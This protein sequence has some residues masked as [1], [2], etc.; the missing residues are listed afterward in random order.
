MANTPRIG[1]VLVHGVGTAGQSD[2]LVDFGESIIGWVAR[3]QRAHGH[4][5]RYGPTRLNF[6]QVD[7]G[8]DGPIPYT[9]LH[10]P[11]EPDGETTQTWVVA[12]AWWA[13]SARP[14]PFLSMLFWSFRYLLSIVCY[15]WREMGERLKR[16]LPQFVTRHDGRWWYRLADA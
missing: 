5:P 12:E 9:T 6:A 14:L 15:L 3:W 2:T 10:V 8:G 16:I 13:A 4:E 11:S 1:V 7:D